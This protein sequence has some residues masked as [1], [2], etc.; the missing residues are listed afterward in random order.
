MLMKNADLVLYSTLT[1]CMNHRYRHD[2]EPVLRDVSLSIAAGE[3]VG[4]CGRTGA[5]KSSLML[6]LYRILEVGGGLVGAWVSGA[7]RARARTQAEAGTIVID[8]VDIADIGLDDLRYAAANGYGVL[9]LTVGPRHTLHCRSRLAII[10]Q[11]PTL[12][13]G[14]MRYNLDVTSAHS[15]EDIW[16][17]LGRVQMKEKVE[18][19]GGL[20]AVVSEGGDNFSVSARWT[21]DLAGGARVYC[22][23]WHRLGSGSCCARLAR[24]CGRRALWCSTRLP[25]VRT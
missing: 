13:S 8:G 9:A 1:I 7:H 17:A 4:V 2:L 6:A 25:R 5:G 3:K 24:C 10:P 16:A 20:E 15:D 23:S 14:T 12:F 19:A 18:A 11:D 21:G 22:A